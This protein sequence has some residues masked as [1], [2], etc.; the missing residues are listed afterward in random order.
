MTH[1]D[2]GNKGVVGNSF[3]DYDMIWT[4]VL[5]SI[6]VHQDMKFLLS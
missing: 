3:K 6:K 5:I 1:R 4:F 2:R